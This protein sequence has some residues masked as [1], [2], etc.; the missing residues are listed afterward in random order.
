MGKE[1]R[2]TILVIQTRTKVLAVEKNGHVYVEY[3]H[4]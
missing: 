3:R 2:K 4:S 1:N